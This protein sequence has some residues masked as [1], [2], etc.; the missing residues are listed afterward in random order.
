MIYSIE[1]YLS[2]YRDD[3]PE[4]LKRYEPGK[5]V[6]F[7]D[8]ISGRIGYYPGSGFDGQLIKLGNRSHSVHTFLYVDYLVSEAL[9]TEHI[10]RP[11]CI[12][13]FHMIGC[14]KYKK[15]DLLPNGSHPLCIS[16]DTICEP[17]LFLDDTYE[18]YCV[19]YIWERDKDRLEDWGAERFATVFLC[20]DGIDAYYQL[21][22]KEYRK[23]PWIFLLKDHGFGCNYDSFGRNSLL[24]KIITSSGIYP[25][26]VLLGENT[27]IWKNYSN[28]YCF[29]E[30]GGM[31]N[32]DRWLFQYTPDYKVRSWNTNG[33]VSDPIFGT[34][35]DPIF[36]E[37]LKLPY[38]ERIDLSTADIIRK[39][40]VGFNRASRLKELLADV[41]SIS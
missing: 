23:A 35:S 11:G 20:D 36:K 16:N 39:F 7:I 13:G 28:T 25:K 24:D 9:L 5:N 26:Y 34:V 8:V 27:E 10:N 38:E 4:W 12:T 41:C 2:K 37:L 14:V 30:M 17:G 22:V 21:F 6:M 1:E 18:W 3:M 31:H 15:S 33:T 19:M 40:C 32:D 29:P